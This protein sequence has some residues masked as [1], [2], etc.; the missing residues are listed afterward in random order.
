MLTN[1]SWDSGWKYRAV[2]KPS[3]TPLEKIDFCGSEQ[4]LLFYIQSPLHKVEPI[5]DTAKMSKDPRRERLWS[6]GEK[7]FF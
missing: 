7:L 3:V 1:Y 6:L 2:D 4:L 5:P